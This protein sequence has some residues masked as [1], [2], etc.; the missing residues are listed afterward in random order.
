MPTP[1]SIYFVLRY[2]DRYSFVNYIDAKTKK[3]AGAA[4]RAA[5]GFS[6][7]LSNNLSHYFTVV[8][9]NANVITVQHVDSQSPTVVHDI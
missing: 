4:Q 5:I 8:I 3:S 1:P 6:A 2:H 7:M 9:S